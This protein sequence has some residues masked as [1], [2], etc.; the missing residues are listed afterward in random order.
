MDCLRSTRLQNLCRGR[1]WF[2]LG[3]IA[4][5]A[6]L[7]VQPASAA[8]ACPGATPL[9]LSSTV[10][11]GDCTGNVQTALP[12]A[13][14]SAPFS[15]SSGKIAGTI[16]SAVY[17]EAGGTV[18]FY[19]QVFNS[20][21]CTS[22]PCDPVIRETDTDYTGWTTGVATRIDG[23]TMTGAGFV[24]G[25]TFPSTADRNLTGDTVGWNFPLNMGDQ[26]NPGH[27]SVVLVITTNATN[28]KAGLAFAIDGGVTQ[29]ASFAPAAGV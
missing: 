20:T 7:C 16:N 22:P 6:T 4:L 21:G 8:L 25:D 18:D 12:L 28:F 10:F 2:A 23:S 1:S 15:A 27:T 5:V 19:Y 17:R 9:A 11:P 3:L 14:L 24:N 29:V 13:T 26:I